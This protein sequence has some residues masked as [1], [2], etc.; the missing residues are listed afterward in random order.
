MNVG[1]LKKKPNS[2]AAV[3]K[4]QLTKILTDVSENRH[5]CLVEPEIAS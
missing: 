1:H 3:L 4:G 5:R 2:H